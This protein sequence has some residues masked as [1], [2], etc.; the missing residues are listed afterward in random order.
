MMDIAVHIAVGEQA[1]EMQRSAIGLHAADEFLPRLGGIDFAALDG[2]VDQL[3]TLGVDLAAAQGVVPHFTVAHIVIGRQTYRRAVRFDGKIRAG[4][5]QFI[6]GGGGG[7]LDHVS[8]L[9]C[10]IAHA[11]HYNK[12]H[13][14]FHDVSS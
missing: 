7:L 8:Q 3:R 6:Q 5:F 9:G 4:G 11:V 14:L 2:L 1:Q 10:A 12:N 13:G